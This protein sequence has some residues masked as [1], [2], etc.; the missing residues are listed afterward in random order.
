[1]AH[2]GEI[3][4]LQPDIIVAEGKK[5]FLPPVGSILKTSNREIVHY[6]VVVNQFVES[7]IPGRVPRPYGLD[8]EEVEEEH[9]QFPYILGWMFQIVF[10]AQ[11]ENGNYEFP[12]RLPRM[13]SLLYEVDEKELFELFNSFDIENAVFKIDEKYFPNRNICFAKMVKRIM[14]SFP[15]YERPEALDKIYTSLSRIFRD[16]FATLRGIMRDIEGK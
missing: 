3:I 12:D 2:I 15:E 11:E 13:H 7:K 6:S 8:E 5:D 4:I 1:M 9:P 10:F 14:K 16:D